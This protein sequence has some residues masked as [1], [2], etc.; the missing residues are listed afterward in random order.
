MATKVLQVASVG[1]Y[2]EWMLETGADKVVA[3]NSPDDDATTNLMTTAAGQRQSYALAASSIPAGS[4]INSVS[5]TLRFRGADTLGQS[6]LRLG[7]TNVDS[8]EH[9]LYYGEGWNTF[10]DTIARPGGGSWALSDLSSLQVGVYSVD[11][12]LYNTKATTLFV[13]VDYTEGAGGATGNM[14]L[15]FA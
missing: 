11:G 8:P 9:H 14:L 4:T 7:T 10:T 13:T 6:F 1:S 2:D 15:M 12:G 3:V 5:V